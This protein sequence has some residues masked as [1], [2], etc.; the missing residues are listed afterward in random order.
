MTIV[1]NVTPSGA[2]AGLDEGEA[3]DNG[4]TLGVVG[5]GAT[6]D[7]DELPWPVGLVNGRP[8]VV[9]EGG[10]LSAVARLLDAPASLAVERDDKTP[11]A[12]LVAVNVPE[13][14]VGVVPASDMVGV[15]GRP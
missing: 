7:A 10:G 6:G 3:G 12:E 4:A 14:S 9:E 5:G 11:R 8:P 13:M 1:T 15:V 2:E